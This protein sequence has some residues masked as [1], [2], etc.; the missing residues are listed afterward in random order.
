MGTAV[1]IVLFINTNF[2]LRHS[3]LRA[4]NL[5]EDPP[6]IRLPDLEGREWTLTGQRG[7]VVLVNFWATWCGPCRREIPDL[8]KIAAEFRGA[9]FD[10]VGIAMDEDGPK[11]VRDFAARQQIGYPILLPSV[12]A[13]QASGIETLPTTYIVDKK[14]RIA[15]TLMGAL[16]RRETIEDV[17]ALLAEP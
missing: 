14:G 9:D 13:I 4:A 3:P 2:G 11:V 5:R 15:K 7:K 6:E 1:L 8:E 10:L 12:R 17:R 16:N